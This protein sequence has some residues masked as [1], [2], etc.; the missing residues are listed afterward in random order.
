MAQIGGM[1]IK[2]FLNSKLLFELIKM[3]NLFRKGEI[4]HDS[5]LSSI[6]FFVQAI[7]FSQDSLTCVK[8]LLNFSAVRFSSLTKLIICLALVF[9]ES[10]NKPREITRSVLVT[11]SH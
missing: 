1:A 4:F 6:S 2:A 8:F 3:K 11:I 7:S 5:K 9:I 10:A